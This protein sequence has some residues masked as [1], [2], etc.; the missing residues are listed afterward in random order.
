MSESTR[1]RL[2]E[3]TDGDVILSIADS[4]RGVVLGIEFCA[5]TGGGKEPEFTAKLR[6][7]IAALVI[8]H[9]SSGL[10]PGAP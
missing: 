5:G 9:S 10:G 4:Q 3:Q 8:K 2:V 7:A 6:E 1:L